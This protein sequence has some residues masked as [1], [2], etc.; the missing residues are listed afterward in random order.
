MTSSARC[1]PRSWCSGRCSARAGEA[2]VSLPGGCA[3][4]NRP[5]DLHL[6]ALEAIGAE[7]E[8]AAGYVKATRA[9]RAA[10]GRALS[11]PGRVGRRDRE[12]ADGGGAGQGRARCIENAAREPEIVD[13]CRC[14]VAMG[15]EIDGIGTRDAGDRGP[16]PAA[17]RDLCGDARPDRGGQLCLRRGDHRRRRSSWSA[18]RRTTC[19]RRSTRWSRPASTV[20]EQADGIRVARRRA[21]RAADALD[22]ALPGLRDRHA[23][24]VHGDAVQAD[25]ASVLTETIFENRYMHVPEL[26]RMGADIA[27]A[28]P[29]RGGA[30]RRQAGRRAGDG[31]R[32]ARLDEPDPRRAGRRGRDAG[33]PR[34][35]SRP[36][37]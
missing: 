8:L 15:A 30:R 36:R 1:A 16:R 37:L 35:S 22:R 3:I 10:G 32:P 13:L 34:L 24:A 12:C 7:I 33:Q 26:A 21:A 29:H 6:K 11:L 4:G 20:E 28:R 14:L 31:D 5:I 25:G 2:T 23:G 17:R 9:R 27:G 19:A 18:P